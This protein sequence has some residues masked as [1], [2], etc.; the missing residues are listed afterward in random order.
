MAW[1]ANELDMRKGF[2]GLSMLIQELLKLDPFSG[3]ANSLWHRVIPSLNRRG[4]A[5]VAN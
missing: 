5:S 4:G 2:D 1:V 3:E